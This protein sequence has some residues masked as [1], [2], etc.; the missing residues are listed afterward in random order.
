MD[1]V[2]GANLSGE[3]T[4][5]DSGTFDI[6]IRPLED[7]ITESFEQVTFNLYDQALNNVAK[8]TVMVTDADIPAI[9]IITTPESPPGTP[10][11]IGTTTG[12]ES[13]IISSLIQGIQGTQGIQGPQGIQGLIGIST[14]ISLQGI[15]GTVSTGI[16]G[17]QGLIYSSQGIQ[18]LFEIQGLQGIQGIQGLIFIKDSPQG[19]QGIQGTGGFQGTQEIQSAGGFQGIQG[20][21]GTGGFQGTQGT[22]GEGF[23]GIQ[24]TSGI[25]GIQGIQGI[26]GTE[27]TPSVIPEGIVIVSPGFGYTSGDTIVVGGIS[28]FIPITTPGGSII[29]VIPDPNFG[30]PSSGVFKSYPTIQINTSKGEGAA[31]FPILKLKRNFKVAPLIINQSGNL[32]VV[33]CI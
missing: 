27:G 12:V 9:T 16:Q 30:L 4:L 7:S 24:G 5:N 11:S 8:T 20:I 2:D 19:I 31:V 13:T 15:G 10:V 33:D 3:I 22:R 28:T 18:N 26:R 21:Q 29:E 14:Y 6:Q 1:E 25:L 32:S 17:I 23:Q